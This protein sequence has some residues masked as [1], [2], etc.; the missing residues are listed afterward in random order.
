MGPSQQP[1]GPGQQ[2]EW[3]AAR[4]R[5]AAIAG[6]WSNNAPSVPAAAGGGPGPV[7]GLRQH[8]RQ[9]QQHQQ[10]QQHHGGT[11]GPPA[12]APAPW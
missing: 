3:A 11:L 2:A 1:Q 9:H 12:G 7:P 4:Q 10:H 8:P 6:G 5:A